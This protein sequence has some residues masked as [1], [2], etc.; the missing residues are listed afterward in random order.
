MLRGQWLPVPQPHEMR[1]GKRQRECLVVSHEG[2][3]QSRVLHPLPTCQ[4]EG[5]PRVFTRLTRR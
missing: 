2:P 1:G 4:N 5:Y 3:V